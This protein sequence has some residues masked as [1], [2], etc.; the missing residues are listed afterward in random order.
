MLTIIISGF[1]F[2]LAGLTTSTA[3]SSNGILR[4]ESN[5]LSLKNSMYGEFM[6]DLYTVFMN[7]KVD[8]NNLPADSIQ[9]YL[10]EFSNM[11]PNGSPIKT[12][13]SISIS[14]KY[15]WRKNPNNGKP[16]FHTGVDINMPL[17]T[18]INSTMSGKVVVVKYTTKTTYGQGYG[19]YV[20]IKNSVGFQT[21]YSHLSR[22][23]VREGQTVKKGQLIATIGITGN[24]TGPNLHYEVYQ[25]GDLKNPLD[26]L[27]MNYNGKMIANK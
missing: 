9:K 12:I 15:G 5:E 6:N 23:Y 3:G 18:K 24:A 27:F 26:S 7:K 10:N 17:H 19:N 13:D 11:Y 8:F 22:I 2:E 25:A 16:Q 20:V 14:S 4:Y 21:L 1:V